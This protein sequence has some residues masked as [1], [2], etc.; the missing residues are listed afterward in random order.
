MRAIP[1]LA[2]LLLLSP[3]ASAQAPAPTGA[4]AFIGRP[5]LDVHILSERQPADEP[6]LLELIETR[7]GR[8][9]SMTD[10]RESISHLFSLGRFQDVQVD[11][12]AAPGGV[13]LTYLL[14][15]IHSVSEVDFRGNLG[16]DEGVVRRTVSDRFGA[17]PPVSR[18]PDVVRALDTLYRDRGF[19]QPS[20][21]WTPTVLHDPD[22]TRLVFDIDAGPRARI[23]RVT[24]TGDPPESRAAFLRQVD[25]APSDPYQPARIQE[26][27]NAYLDKLRKRGRYEAR[28]GFTRS[29][30]V[31]GTVDLTFEVEP[32]PLV[33]VTFKGDPLPAG[34]RKELVPVEREGSIDQ[35]RIEDAVRRITDY[36]NRQGYWKASATPARVEGEGTVTIVFTVHQ[37]L[38]YRTGPGGVEV[39]GNRTV[40][41][42][43]LRPLLVKLAEG[44]V[45]VEAD[46]QNAVLAIGDFYRRRGYASVK[47]SSAPNELNPADGAGQVKPVIVI[48]EGP[49]TVVGNITFEG[50]A[51]IPEPQ[52]RAKLSVISGAPYYEPDIAADRD[53]LLLEYRNAGFASAD[54]TIVPV[55]NDDRTRADLKFQVSEG[56]RTFVD[57]ILIVGNTK[58][59]PRIIRRELLIRTG[60]PLGL[61]DVVE[62]QQRLSQLGLFRRVRITEVPQSPLGQRDVLVT[63]EEAAATTLSYGGGLEIQRRQ[64]AGA[65]GQVEDNYDF[66]PRGFFDV[67]RRNIGGRNRSVNLY[68]RASL[69]PK[70]GANETGFGF[71]EYRAVATYREPRALNMNADVTV[72]GGLEQG[73][74]SGFNFKRQGLTADAGRRLA[75]GVRANLR[76]S[77]NTTKTFDTTLPTTAP[78]NEKE[79]FNI[80]RV[81]PQ[82]RLSAFSGALS[83]DTRDDPLDA[84]RGTFLSAEGTLAA[85]SLGGQVGFVKSFVQG[86]W[87]HRVAGASRVVF[88]SRA[89]LG[90]ADGFPRQVEVTD[91]NGGVVIATI[92]DL[93]ASERFFAGGGSTIRGFALDSVGAAK[94]ISPTGFARGGNAVLI[95]NAELRFPGWSRFGGA[96]F[97]DG[98]NVFERASE[99]DLG[100]LRGS[101]GF[102]LRVRSPM[103]PIRVDVGFKINRRIVAGALEHR[104]A[105]IHFSI[106]QAF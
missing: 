97:V 83:R 62:S 45:F 56:P 52:L 91:E 3:G 85:R 69:R 88:A 90:F 87:F 19:L 82:V 6:G 15:P 22:R 106:G 61:E 60:Q 34:K 81:F 100:D 2:L 49:Q 51:G 31:D 105:G 37:G 29:D 54:V 57:H 27:L 53:T 92:D 58:T 5:V 80:D 75:P 41:I 24:I 21:R 44:S 64:R 47:V 67:G 68:T 63:V 65:D 12:T 17:T 86:F 40:P 4:E 26:R 39:N 16:L 25:A 104:T 30:P 74:R 89:A 102:G 10:V 20:V 71:S 36:L 66:A 11:A 18:A 94:T 59:D 93:P 28:A 9:L 70:N 96:V 38:Q 13:R 35:D 14:V 99:F 84:E 78:R 103:G 1:V 33:T 98:G 8:P 32:G 42:E 48:E 101:V 79:R 55:P 46:L 23:G 76:Y 43:Q 7:P 72:T 50:N 95:A 73:I 77:F